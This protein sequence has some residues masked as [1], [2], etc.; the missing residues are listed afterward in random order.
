MVTEGDS[1][2]G[3]RIGQVLTL[4][5]QRS[6]VCRVAWKKVAR[7]V[8]STI[9]LFTIYKRTSNKRRYKGQKYYSIQH[10]NSRHLETRHNGYLWY[11]DWTTL[12][13]S[14]FLIKTY[15]NTIIFIFFIFFKIYQF[16]NIAVKN[17]SF[18]IQLNSNDS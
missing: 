16:P 5:T 11:C 10:R 3:T 18:K 7:E 2:T 15:I 9:I 17:V 6:T 12:N 4:V 8:R 14:F 1:V 13:S